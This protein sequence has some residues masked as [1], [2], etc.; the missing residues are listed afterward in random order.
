MKIAL[1]GATG[2][3]GR[4]ITELLLKRKACRADEIHLFASSNSAGKIITIEGHSYTIKDTAACIFADYSLVLF[5]TESPVSRKY[6][7][8]ALNA[9]CHAIDISSA[10]RLQSDIP[11]VVLPVNGHLVN[12]E[13]KQ[14]STPNC[15][16]SPIA[17]VL[18]PLHE[19]W[20]VRRVV[21]STYQSASGAGKDPMDELF[22]ES[23][24]HLNGQ[25]AETKYFP[26]PLPFNV[27][28]QVD[29][30][31]ED[32]FSYEEFKIIREVQ[33]L[34]SSEIKII[35]TAVR[36]PV[37]IGHSISLS[38]EFEKPL[39]LKEVKELLAVSPGIMLSE[40]HYSTPIEVV[41]QDKVFVGRL[42]KD[43][44]VENG[45]ALWT[46][47]DNLRRGAALDAV[48]IAE[49]LLKVDV[50]SPRLRGEALI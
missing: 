21:A 40:N 24:R 22:T 39:E 12:S 27:I 33:K 2:N 17:V 19:R 49:A 11:L 23:S 18:K 50:Y 29:K 1:I 31:L 15:L 6:M 8:E 28:P 9:G 26:R 41:G 46:A 38:I 34:V 42:R 13:Q 48:E 43:P 44:T 20:H 14:Y 35:A 37:G 45:I 25:R 30:I 5:A 10:Y 36:V 3:V 16:A 32:G 4:I 7:P 47:H